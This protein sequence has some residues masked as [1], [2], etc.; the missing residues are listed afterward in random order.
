MKIIFLKDVKGQGKKD[1][2]KEVKDGYAS[3]L[4]KSGCAVQY[5]NK[6]ASVLDSELKVRKE[7]EEALVKAAN[8]EKTKLEKLELSFKVKVGEQDKVFGSVTSKQICEELKKKEYN[9]D[10]KKILIDNDINTLGVHIVKV[11]LHKNV[12]ASLKVVLNK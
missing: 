11:V 12:I 10:K 8:I 6:S 1:D 9:I 5:T 4:I 3:Y 7:N 2:I